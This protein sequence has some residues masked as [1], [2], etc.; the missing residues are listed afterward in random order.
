MTYF[1]R[2]LL[3]FCVFVGGFTTV[4]CCHS[5]CVIHGCGIL[6]SIFRVLFL[7]FFSVCCF[8]LLLCFGSLHCSVSVLAW[9]LFC[10]LFACFL[11]IAFCLFAFCLLLSCFLLFVCLLVY[12]CLSVFSVFF[13]SFTIGLFA[14]V[15]FCFCSFV[16]CF[17]VCLFLTCSFVRPFAFGCCYTSKKKTRNSEKIQ[18]K[19]IQT[20]LIQRKFRENV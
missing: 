18:R 14:F 16:S 4:F 19:T 15:C 1:P 17:F 5:F 2:V 13:C 8:L 12:S 20:F 3:V 10:C 6:L 11:F 9:F 7:C